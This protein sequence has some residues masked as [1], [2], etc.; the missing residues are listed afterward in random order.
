M[1]IRKYGTAG[2]ATDYL[3]GFQYTEGSLKFVPTSEGYFNFENNKYIYNY[4]D[5]LGNVRLSYFHN[6]SGIEVL[7]ENNY[8]PFG[9][10]H[11][12]YN[13]LAGNP[14]YK[15]K[16]NGK[17]L[18]E[19]GMYDYGAR[20]YMPDIGRW[21]VVDELA[22]KSRRFSTYTYAL[23]NPIMFV[24]PDGRQGTDWFN[25]SMGQMEFRYDVKSQRDLDDK[26]IKGSYVGETAQQGSLNYAAD[27]V[28]YDE[29]SGGKPIADGRV[30]DI[31]EVKITPKSVVKER[32]LQ[33][34]R[35]RL[36]AAEFAMFGKYAIGI[37]FGGAFAQSSVSLT[38]AYNL[39]TEQANLFG[40]YGDLDL[41]SIGVGF[42]FNQ[43]NAFG[44]MP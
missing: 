34:A 10:K 19:T 41:P 24:D 28:V 11:E 6:G 3:D 20:F 13:P 22:E 43:M 18:Q 9:L 30:Y 38:L 5:H 8:Y 21:G 14:S 33:A 44:T 39:G 36:G 35:T 17:E 15:Y 40:T 32:N 26:G 25:N 42:Q 1:K 7:E 16:Y 27:G 4:T 12:G 29:S 37:T 31:G 23:D 2:L